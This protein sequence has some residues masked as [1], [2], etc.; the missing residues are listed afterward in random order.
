MP[1]RMGSAGASWHACRMTIN[2]TSAAGLVVR[3]FALPVVR[4]V[5]LPAA[6]RGSGW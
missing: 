1:A 3:V 5:P 2:V 4:E 6:P